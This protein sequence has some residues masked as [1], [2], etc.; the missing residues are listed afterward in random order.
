MKTY[1]LVSDV[2]SFYLPLIKALNKS[3]FD[4]NNQDHILVVLGD[5][6]DRGFETLQVYKFLTSLSK[7]R[8]ILIRGNHESLYLELLTKGFPESYDFTNGTVRTFCQIAGFDE[9]V[10]DYGYWFAKAFA[11][12]RA[13]DINELNKYN[14]MPY[15]MWQ[16]IKEIVAMSDV[17]KWLK[18]DAWI[19]YFETNKY[20][21]VHS[22]IPFKQVVRDY[23]HIECLGYRDDWR[24]AT[25]TEW[26]DAMWVCPWSYAKQGHNKTGKTIVCG[27]WHTSDFFN[28]LTRQHKTRTQNPIFNSKKYKLI[29]LDACTA[30]TNKINVLVLKEDEL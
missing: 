11:E 3:G 13:G 18:S 27:H 17:T 9:Q 21:M 12:S 23:Y 26:E 29:G 20:I 28:H 1:Y 15:E 14:T 25:N 6:F 22:W 2:H 16:Q 19:N 5:V 7:D 30:L 10:L 24:N 8:L 4:I